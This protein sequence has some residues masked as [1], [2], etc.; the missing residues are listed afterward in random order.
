MKT[1]RN[2]LL[3]R[4]HVLFNE[5]LMWGPILIVSLQNLAHMS[6]A[7]IYF[8]ESAIL[9]INACSD[10]PFGA[11]ADKIGRKKTIIIGRALLFLSAV[12]FACMTNPYMAWAGNMFWAIGYSLQSGAD[13]A[14]LYDSLRE[15]GRESEY[16]RIEGNATGSRLAVIAA[17]AFASGFI[18]HINLRWPMYISLPFLLIPFISA[19]FFKE[20]VEP[21]KFSMKGQYEALKEGGVY[22]LQSKKLRWMI[23]FAALLATTS[24][25]WFFTY[26]PYFEYVH[27]PLQL[28]GVLFFML[29]IVAWLTSHYAYKIEHYLGE[30]LCIILMVMCLGVPIILMARFPSQL[31]ACLILVQNLVRGLMKPFVSDYMNRNIATDMRATVLSMQ[32]SLANLVSV[33][34]LA[35]FGLFTANF[36][37]PTSLMILGIIALTLGTW[38]YRTYVKQIN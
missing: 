25:V 11:L 4:I 10:I 29:N 5:P 16:K 36:N 12:F 18:A 30:R 13:V 20:T 1:S 31:F 26:N 7:S 2:I 38:S 21:K 27:I 3:Y 15:Q 32:S 14:L 19:F 6:L 8:M 9:C 28:Y 35:V 22:L 33:I 23:A 24:K 34:G 17:C 37:L